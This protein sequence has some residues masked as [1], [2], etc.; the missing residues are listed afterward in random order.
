MPKLPGC[1]ITFSGILQEY[2]KLKSPNHSTGSSQCLYIYNHML[3]KY[4]RID[5]MTKI[6]QVHIIYHRLWWAMFFSI[7]YR[8]GHD[9]DCFRA[10]FAFSSPPPMS[11]PLARARAHPNTLSQREASVHFLSAVLKGCRASHLWL[12]D[13]DSV[14]W[15]SS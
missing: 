8:T 15:L 7:L 12:A 14:T 10:F 1:L 5:S 11:F 6:I 4:R 3:N 9:I 2:F 13:H